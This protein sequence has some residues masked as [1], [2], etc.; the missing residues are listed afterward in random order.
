[1]FENIGLGELFILLFVPM[2]VLFIIALVDIVK[3]NFPGN[4]KL[5]WVLIILFA[6]LVG[7]ILYLAIGA[8]QKI[9]ANARKN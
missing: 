2:L 8:K 9:K 3:S 4:N 1:M 7:P 6:P 5:M